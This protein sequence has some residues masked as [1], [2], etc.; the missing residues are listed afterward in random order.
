MLTQ[1]KVERVK[2]GRY[3]DGQT[4]PPSWSGERSRAGGSRRH[5]YTDATRVNLSRNLSSIWN[6]HKKDPYLGSIQR[7]SHKAHPPAN[8]TPTVPQPVL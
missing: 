5:F 2:L 3:G 7:S 8:T 6:L 4:E 1:R